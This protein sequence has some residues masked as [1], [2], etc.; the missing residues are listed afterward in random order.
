M[1]LGS[2]SREQL[3]FQQTAGCGN[4][5]VYDNKSKTHGT[6]WH[7]MAPVA[8]ATGA[9]FEVLCLYTHSVDLAGNLLDAIDKRNSEDW[10]LAITTDHGGGACRPEIRRPGEIT[11]PP[12]AIDFLPTLSRDHSPLEPDELKRIRNRKLGADRQLII[13]TPEVRQR[14]LGTRDRYLLL[15]CDGVWERFT[16]Q[17]IVDF[18][19]LRLQAE[20][21]ISRAC[22][23]VLDRPAV[24]MEPVTE[25]VYE[26][27][28]MLRVELTFLAVFAFLW[29]AGQVLAKKDD[30]KTAARKT[31]PGPR[32]TTGPRRE[33][34][35]PSTVEPE[36]LQ[37]PQWVVAQ[38]STLCRSQVQRALELY[39]DMA[40]KDCQQ[41]YA[42][43]VTAVIRV[44]QAD[45][46]LSLM[47][48]SGRA[49]YAKA[50]QM[51]MCF[52]LYE[53][54]RSRGLSP[55]QV[56]Y[57]ILLDGFIND[58]EAGP[59]VVLYTTLIKGFARAGQVDQ[60]MQIYEEMRKETAPM[61]MGS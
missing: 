50:G 27:L 49:G 25:L 40:P 42:N 10:L 61:H 24:S 16:N 57:G 44:G 22:S 26:G 7:I 43:L 31:S 21:Q 2:R 59:A 32:R 3:L 36:K 51:D 5:I 19:L 12:E 39:R 45:D 9:F 6:S 11:P 8:S 15:G 41:L 53:V 54:M 18:L 34:L 33:D 48:E 30:V 55:S 38:V 52:E 17:Q 28:Y 20:K 35:T 47:K 23:A 58:N 4:R 60:A 14:K 46:A 56:T 37:D 1:L 29:L 13:A